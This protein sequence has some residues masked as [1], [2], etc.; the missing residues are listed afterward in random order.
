M[1]WNAQETAAK[2]LILKT[3]DYLS[4]QTCDNPVIHL[5]SHYID[6]DLKYVLR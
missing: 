5:T 2:V 6:M 1:K 4:Q 3:I